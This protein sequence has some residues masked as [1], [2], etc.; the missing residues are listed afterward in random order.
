MIFL[1]GSVCFRINSTSSNTN[2][3]VVSH[4]NMFNNTKILIKKYDNDEDEESESDKCTICFRG[5]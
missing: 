1:I 5:Y 3:E 2:E 4:E